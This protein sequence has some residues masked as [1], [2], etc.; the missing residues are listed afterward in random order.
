MTQEGDQV[1]PFYLFLW[2]LINVFM[3]AA[4]K[5]ISMSKVGDLK[6]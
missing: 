3:K 2:L 1:D 4:S 6:K 5:K